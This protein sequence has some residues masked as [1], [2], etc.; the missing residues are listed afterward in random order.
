M[1][2]KERE[3]LKEDPFQQF[4]EKVW[5]TLTQYR[6]MIFIGL[7]AVTVV[8]VIIL[9]VVFIKSSIAASENRIYTQALSIRDNENL[10]ID[11]K[12]EK[13]TRIEYKSGISA[14]VPLF[15]ATLC[16]ERG[17]LSKAEQILK[18]FPDSSSRLIMDE[19]QLLQAE[20]LNASDKAKEALE[21]LNTL[22]SDA[23]AEVPKDCVLIKMAKIQVKN[24]QTEAALT[25]LN[26]FNTEYPQSSY[27]PEATSLLKQLEK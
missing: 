14:V 12:I 15:T 8:V 17:D 21:L 3:H 25:N 1:K 7:G 5:T 16:F 22:Y 6:K 2:K 11:Q 10:T 26:K 23:N 20:I 19:K 4:I 24:G 27:A 18:N 9:L 13:L